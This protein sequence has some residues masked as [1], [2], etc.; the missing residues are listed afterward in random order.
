MTDHAKTRSARC[1]SRGWRAGR[2]PVRVAGALLTLVMCASAQ[3]QSIPATVKIIVPFSA[4]GAQDTLAREL[5]RELGSRLA[6]PFVVDNRPGAGGNIGTDAAAKAV[7]DGSVLVLSSS[8]PLANNRLFYKSMPYDPD[9]DFTPVALV[10]ETP[11]FIL[12][13][14]SFSYASLGALLRDAA[15]G[16]TPL[17]FGS[18]GY[19]TTSHLALELLRENSRREIRHIPYKGGSQVEVD[20]L[21]SVL[22]GGLVLYSAGNLAH[23]EKGTLRI[24]AVT[25]DARMSTAPGV[26]TVVEEG[27]PMLVTFTWFALVGPRGLPKDYVNR[28]NREVN[29]YLRS[30]TGITRL[31]NLGISATIGPPEL[32]AQRMREELS[33]WTPIVRK[34]NL[35][36]D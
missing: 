21:A 12:A 22:D 35:K 15:Q 28:M 9:K 26:P 10:G 18:A 4:G 32:V 1:N 19:G 11:L 36:M 6:I 30:T 2:L 3:A 33:K 20:V 16:Q 5:A 17:N 27:L 14:K 7:P 25:S 31:Q 29:E 24:L 8:G 34:H 13:K 23:L